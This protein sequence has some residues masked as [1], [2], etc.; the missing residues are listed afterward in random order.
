MLVEITHIRVIVLYFVA[1][2]AAE[3]DLTCG[4]VLSWSSH[5]S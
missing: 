4:A 5:Y 2:V 1:H 3:G